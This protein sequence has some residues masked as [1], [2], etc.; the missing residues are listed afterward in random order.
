MRQVTAWPGAGY[1]A[2]LSP[3]FSTL[4]QECRYGFHS[5]VVRRKWDDD[6]S[7]TVLDTG[8]AHGNYPPSMTFQFLLFLTYG[9]QLYLLWAR[10]FPP[11]TISA[12]RV[13]FTQHLLKSLKHWGWGDKSYAYLTHQ[14]TFS[15]STLKL[16]H[17]S[18]GVKPLFWKT[19]PSILPLLLVPL[20][21]ESIK[22]KMK[23]WLPPWHLL[24][25]INLEDAML[26]Q[27][28]WTRKDKHCTIQFIWGT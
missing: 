4:T 27:I 26:D 6:V 12:I 10:M 28:S 21:W 17:K 3:C 18:E 20:K 8:F 1:V 25:Q 23:N 9:S 5:V 11:T 16:L 13:W 24:R 19:D 14:S 7:D 2:S 15:S 22:I